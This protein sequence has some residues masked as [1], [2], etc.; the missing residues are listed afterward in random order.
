MA[1]E[2]E[3]T[4]ESL[5][6]HPQLA[7][8]LSVGIAATPVKTLVRRHLAVTTNC[9]V[10]ELWYTS[11]E[12]KWRSSPQHPCLFFPLESDLL[13]DMEARLTLRAAAVL[14]HGITLVYAA[15][16]HLLLSKKLHHF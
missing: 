12:G 8:A 1:A 2:E 11:S 9:S 5:R 14:Q 15:Q 13:M 7:F 3:A 16:V 10:T 6:S 4:V